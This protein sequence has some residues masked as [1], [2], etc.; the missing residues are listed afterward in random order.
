MQQ[1][2][3]KLELTWIGK[4]NRPR[5][6]PRILIEDPDLSYHAAHKVTDYDTFDNRLI[7]GDNLLAL[8][9]LE[10][11]FTGKIKC[12]YI[13]PP[14]NTN[15]VFDHYDDGLEHSLWLS[16]IRD[17]LEILK[18][19]LHP[20]GSLFIHIDDNEL[21]YLI[22][23]TDEVLGRSNRI[24]IITFKQ[25]SASGPKTVNPG[26]VT[27]ANYILYYARDRKL[28]TPRRAF[29]PVSRDKRYSK[30]IANFDA[31]YSEWR[32]ISLRE[33]YESNNGASTKR[34][35]ESRLDIDAELTNLF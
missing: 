4:E 33:A 34:A 29:V 2:K 26:L 10:N 1:R 21:G 15:Q 30:F 17:R 25:S 27:T 28:W 18:A 16:L 8:K 24:S 20:S 7:C 12:I 13:D 3:Q 19:L 23:L 22:V 5:L 11:E 32:L 6:E 35:M 31:P 9:A 14:F